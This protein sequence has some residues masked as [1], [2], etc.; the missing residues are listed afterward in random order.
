MAADQGDPDGGADT[1]STIVLGLAQPIPGLGPGG[2]AALAL[3]LA[4]AAFVTLRRGF[5]A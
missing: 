3:L 4:A 5:G 1:S 2:I